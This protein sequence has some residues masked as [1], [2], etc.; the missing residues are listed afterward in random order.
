MTETISDLEMLQMPDGATDGPAAWRSAD[1]E[2]DTGWRYV[3]S[4]ADIRELD[5]ALQST[6]T[7]GLEIIQINSANFPLP[8]LS[9]RLRQM[10]GDVLN[11]RG[12]M[13]IR[14]VPVERYS[15]EESA[16][17]FFGIGAHMGSL[18]SQNAD[19]HV[20]GHVCDLSHDY[21]TNANLRGYRAGGPL[22][23]HTDSVDIVGLLCLRAAKEGGAS[24][25]VSASTIHNEMLK[26]RPDLVKE[27]YRPIHRD[28]R[29][30]VPEGKDPWWIMP[31][32]QWYEGRM[33]SHFSDVYIRSVERFPEA[34]RFTDAQFE[35]FDLIQKIAEDPT[36]H[37]SMEFREGDIQLVNNHE[38]LHGRSD[39]QDWDDPARQRYLLRLWI[40]PPNGR[41]LPPAYAER[42]GNIDI[43]DRGGIVCPETEFKAPLTPI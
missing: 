35:T 30:E 7:Q 32:F 5:E 26:Q 34:P 25:I 11:G 14:G 3:L 9:K 1:M 19:G 13:Q 24:K 17:V 37:L 42:Y 43:G 27:L 23:F 4:D 20:L 15:I 10:R 41:A 36:N 18:R 39:Y 33:N 16:R 40:C 8:T 38:I 2:A 21:K 6:V 28:R 12:F 31:I 29:G 22:K